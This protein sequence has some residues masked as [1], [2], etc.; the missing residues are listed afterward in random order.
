MT[1]KLTTPLFGEKDGP[2]T[3][4]NRLRKPAAVGIVKTGAGFQPSSV[5]GIRRCVR[6]VAL[7]NDPQPPNGL[8]AGLVVSQHPPF[9]HA[10]SHV[11]EGRQQVVRLPRVFIDKIEFSGAMFR[12]F[13]L[14]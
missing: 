8:F 6:I 12:P 5:L 3:M 2:D 1:A 14:C 9:G 4:Y 10:N 7:A 13:S 11:V